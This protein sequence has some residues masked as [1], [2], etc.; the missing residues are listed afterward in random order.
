MDRSLARLARIGMLG[1]LV[2]LA[3]ATA[4]PAAAATEFRRT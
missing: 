4:V 3:L 1:L 2:S